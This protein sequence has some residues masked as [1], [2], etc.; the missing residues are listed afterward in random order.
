MDSDSENY[1]CDTTCVTGDSAT[2]VSVHPKSKR[3]TSLMD[4]ESSENQFS[5]KTK[6]KRCD[7]WH[8]EEKK[9]TQILDP[10]IEQCLNTK[11]KFAR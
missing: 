4:E 2:G 5:L 7:T 9:E 8:G 6:R 3:M 10:G 1:I 11:R